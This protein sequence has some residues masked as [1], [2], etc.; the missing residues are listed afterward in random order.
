M[1]KV[2]IFDS[3]SHHSNIAD[4]SHLVNELDDALWLSETELLKGRLSWLGSNIPFGTPKNLLD[5]REWAMNGVI[6]HVLRGDFSPAP[7]LLKQVCPN[8]PIIVTSH[9]PV[10]LLGQVHIDTL[11]MAD[12]LF[13]VSQ[14]Q[15]S[16]LR[17]AGVDV[18]IKH[19]PHGISLNAFSKHLIASDDTNE[20]KEVLCVG[21]HLRDWTCVARVFKSLRS[22]YEVPCRFIV[23][24][25]H[26]HLP[27]LKDIAISLS[28]SDE[29]Y[30]Q[31]LIS[32]YAMCLPLTGA[33]AN[34]AILEAMALGCP[35]V[36]SDLPGARE[37]LGDA[38]LFFKND[39]PQSAVSAV[40][41]LVRE[42]GLR[43][44][45]RKRGKDRIQEYTWTVLVPKY[46]DAYM[47]IMNSQDIKN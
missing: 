35:L 28:L 7:L 34:N 6:F 13:V 22:E 5:L 4:Y 1:N 45:L 23:P 10:Q 20:R 38:A 3:C 24:R 8:A 19:L 14:S 46:Q 44:E 33:T 15:T 36:C 41:A 37:Y 21:E 43:N 40:Y 29:E 26:H 32:C 47:E 16:Q 31:S 25:F 2:L 11:G 27:I 18:C 12:C 9:Q 30:F 39:D 17:K 42:P